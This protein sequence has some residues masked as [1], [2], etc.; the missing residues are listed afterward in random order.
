ME[1]L[2]TYLYPS[3]EAVTRPRLQQL[4]RVF[5]EEYRWVEPIRYGASDLRKRL[6]PGR[7]DYE[8]LADFYEGYQGLCIGAH[9]DQHYIWVFAPNADRPGFSGGT[10]IWATAV[11]EAERPDWRSRHLEHVARVMRDTDSPLAVSSLEEDQERKTRRLV[12]HPRGVGKSEV[13]TVIMPGEGLA[14]LFWRNFYGPPFTRLFGERLLSLPPGT[15]QDLGDGLALVQP[16]ELPSQARTPEGDAAE[17]RL[18]TVLGPE[19]F[20][21]H[22]RHQKPSRVPVLSPAPA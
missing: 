7:I 18:I 3:S 20:Y 19:C 6:V 22:A 10:L 14:G 1:Y 21:D 8:A 16:Y 13:P 15:H 4:L 12:P 5:L 17:A 11:S 2:T 9:T